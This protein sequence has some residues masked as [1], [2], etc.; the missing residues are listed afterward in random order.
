MKCGD[1]GEYLNDTNAHI[2]IICRGM[3]IWISSSMKLVCVTYDTTTV[4]EFPGSMFPMGNWRT[5]GLFELI[6]NEFRFSSDSSFFLVVTQSIATPLSNCAWRWNTQLNKNRMKTKTRNVLV[7]TIL[8]TERG[9]FRQKRTI[10]SFRFC[11]TRVWKHFNGRFSRRSIILIHKDENKN[12]C[13]KQFG[14]TK[15]VVLSNAPRTKNVWQSWG[16][17]ICLFHEMCQQKRQK[18]THTDHDA[19]G[20]NKSHPKIHQTTVQTKSVYWRRKSFQKNTCIQL[21]SVSERDLSSKRFDN[22]CCHVN[23]CDQ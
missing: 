6:R 11:L 19:L 22:F 15:C 12:V 14:L 16:V 23:F 9:M 4:T 20:T 3:Q 1:G 18:K 17:P 8:W 7:S 13:E 10:R 2:G 5:F 21:K